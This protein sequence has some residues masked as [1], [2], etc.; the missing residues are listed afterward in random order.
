M[1]R[2]PYPVVNWEIK[3]LQLNKVCKSSPFEVREVPIK[4]SIFGTSASG[5]PAAALRCVKCRL[6]NKTQYIRH[7]CVG[8]ACGLSEVCEVIIG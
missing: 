6:V 2:S 4:Q 1:R 7:L 8:A 5:T 3:D